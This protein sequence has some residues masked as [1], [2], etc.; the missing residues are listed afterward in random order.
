VSFMRVE[1]P[2]AVVAECWQKLHEAMRWSR[3][4]LNHAETLKIST[5]NKHQ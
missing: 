4:M 5:T 1:K 3:K 2:Y